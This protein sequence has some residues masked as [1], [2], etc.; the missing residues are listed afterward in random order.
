[1]PENAHLIPN[2]SHERIRLGQPPFKT[3]MVVPLARMVVPLARMVVPLARMVVPLARMVVPL[4]R[5][6]CKWEHRRGEFLQKGK[7][8]S[9]AAPFKL[10]HSFYKLAI[11]QQCL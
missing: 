11:E 2:W 8:A 4:A 3:D 9:R 1:M 6:N 7:L 5:V 10:Q